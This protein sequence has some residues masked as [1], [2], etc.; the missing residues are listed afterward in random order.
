MS[1]KHTILFVD[2]ELSVLDALRRALHGQH[3]VWNMHFAQ[4]VD[5]ALEKAHA[6]SF[7]AIVTDV[8]MPERDGLDL[9]ATLQGADPT[10]DIP[11]VILTG[12]GDVDLKRRA[13]ELGAVDLLSK[14]IIAE[15]LIARLRSVLRLKSYQDELK[16]HNE[17]LAQ[18]TD[19]AHR[20]VEDVAHEFRTPLT[21]IKEFA[22]ILSDGIGGEV[23]E[24]QT[25]YL[26]F[27][28]DASRNLAHLIDDFLDSSKLRARTLRVDRREHS[29]ADLIDSSWP[30]L[31]SRASAKRVVLERQIENGLPTVFADA[32]KVRRTLINLAVNAIKC[33][34]PD[35]V[36]T[37]SA[38]TGDLGGIVISVTDR[39]P[40]FPE[41]EAQRL[42]E[43]FRQGGE[44]NRIS[45]KGFGLGLNIV[46]DLVA[47]NLGA[48]SVSSTLGEGSTFSFTLPR[49]DVENI[50]DSFIQRTAERAPTAM[51]SVLCLRRTFPESS[52]GELQSFGASVCHATDIQLPGQDGR[53]IL[54]VGET[55]EP[56]RW[57]DRLIRQDE[58]NRKHA[59]AG[60]VGQLCVEQI[61]TWS[62][63]DARD[64]ILGIVCP[65]KE[66]KC[67]A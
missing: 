13:L 15:D 49:C 64:V 56:D 59:P 6:M 62:L 5:E 57:K 36:V 27:I 22:S 7:D 42:F 51:L 14:P 63:R 35:G 25:E 43:R 21:V 60:G 66:V 58:E 24:K 11:V 40:G 31:E 44:A 48:V 9:L 4:S 39:G 17:T 47:I 8:T 28:T 23:T 16:A 41:D 33:S 65:S 61:G 30:M 10:S 45:T 12:L 37:V 19:T 29:V 1:K 34:N 52:V 26:Q 18:L 2:D 53:S 50:V 46:K 20:F 54:I 55:I 67:C 32:D 3:D 38:C